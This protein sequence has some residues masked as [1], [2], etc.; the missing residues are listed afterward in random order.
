MMNGVR[1]LEINA[2]FAKQCICYLPLN[3]RSSLPSR[4]TLLFSFSSLQALF[5]TYSSLQHNSLLF[6][7]PHTTKTPKLHPSIELK[8]SEVLESP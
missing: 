1:M 7:F 8:V 4:L 5:F 3:G 2:P 6:T